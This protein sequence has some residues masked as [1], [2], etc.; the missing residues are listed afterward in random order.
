MNRELIHQSF[1]PHFTVTPSTR[2]PMRLT[3]SPRSGYDQ[4]PR[5]A[6]GRCF[7]GHR[8]T[9]GRRRSLFRYPEGVLQMTTTITGS[10]SPLPNAFG[11]PAPRGLQCAGTPSLTPHLSAPFAPPPYTDRP[12][13]LHES[14]SIRE[15]AQ[16]LQAFRSGKP[17]SHVSLPRPIH[18]PTPRRLIA[19]SPWT[20]GRQNCLLNVHR[21]FILRE[22]RIFGNP[23]CCGGHGVLQT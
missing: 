14:A 13:T 4:R 19:R 21:T 22:A 7:S 20:H 10:P 2:S 6:G 11:A 15:P 16:S 1:A 3:S 17:D 18:N 8:R 5:V 23:R 9:L 12:A